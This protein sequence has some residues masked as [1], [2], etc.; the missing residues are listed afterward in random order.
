MNANYIL[1]LLLLLCVYR[2]LLNGALPVVGVRVQY[3][4]HPSGGMGKKKK[5]KKKLFVYVPPKDTDS[6][7]I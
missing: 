6:D 1:I 4:C 3:Y 7:K 2:N 5:K